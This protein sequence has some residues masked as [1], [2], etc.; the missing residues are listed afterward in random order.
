MSDVVVNSFQELHAAIGKRGMATIYRGVGDASY[1]LIPKAGRSG[2]CTLK[3][4]RAMLDLFQIHATPHLHRLPQ[5]QWEW[6]FIAQH[7]GLPTRLLD[8]TRNPLVAAFFAVEGGGSQDAAIYIW[9]ASQVLIERDF[10]DPFSVPSAVTCLPRHINTRIAAQAGVFTIQ[11]QP[12]KPLLLDPLERIIIPDSFR[13]E[14]RRILFRYNL[15]RGTLFP[16]LDG[17]AKFIEWYTLTADEWITEDPSMKP[18]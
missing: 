13:R 18:R 6:L 17:Q 10:P 16:D 14:L 8:W 1:T 2:V 4:E 9:K 3:V 15:H 12:L 11:P 5:N 7:H